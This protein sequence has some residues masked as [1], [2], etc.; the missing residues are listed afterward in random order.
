MP[1]PGDTGFF[2][3]RDAAFDAV[4]SLLAARLDAATPV[5]TL[6]LDEKSPDALRDNA[7]KDVWTLFHGGIRHLKNGAPD[8]GPG[9][10][11]EAISRVS[12]RAAP[13]AAALGIPPP[14]FEQVLLG[15]DY[16]D[17]RA[18]AFSLCRHLIGAAENDFPKSRQI[19]QQKILAEKPPVDEVKE[20]MA[21]SFGVLAE[22][23]L[24]ACGE[25]KEELD[26]L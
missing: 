20:Q 26:R 16:A 24:R 22:T 19:I 4:L 13:L 9:T 12:L 2:P 5:L 21:L 10:M 25:M 14:H 23:Y 15:V 8:G 17:G 6:Q 11:T 3:Q 1:S 18:A 7:A